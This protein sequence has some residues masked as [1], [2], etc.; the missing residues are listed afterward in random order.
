MKAGDDNIHSVYSLYIMDDGW[1]MIYPPIRNCW[2]KF[3]VFDVLHF[4]FVVVRLA[5]DAIADAPVITTLARDDDRLQ[6]WCYDWSEM[7]CIVCC[8]V[9]TD[10]FPVRTFVHL[11]AVFFNPK[12]QGKYRGSH[13]VR[14]IFGVR[15]RLPPPKDS[16][17]VIALRSYVVFNNAVFISGVLW[18]CSQ[19]LP[20]QAKRKN[21]LK[22]VLLT[23]MDKT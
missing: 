18:A 5:K 6:L 1:W 14:I 8:W 17:S 13:L 10:F 4:L 22:T 19:N 20:K 15:L 23:F 9:C 16:T 3:V 11:S 7:R 21:A 12:P 2:N